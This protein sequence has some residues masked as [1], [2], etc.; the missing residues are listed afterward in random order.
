MKTKKGLSTIVGTVIIIALVIVVGG[1][2]FGV[3]RGIVNDKLTKSK[4]CFNI[5]NKIT[6][7]QDYTCYNSTGNYFQFSI[8]RKKISLDSLKIA[9]SFG[10][11]SKIFTLTNVSQIVPRLNNYPNNN[12]EV[13]LPNNS[14]RSTY[15]ANGIT[16]MPTLIEISPKRMG[17]NCDVADK[18]SSILEC[19]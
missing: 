15:I 8:D 13:M 14:S 17:N 5:Y 11:G 18:I 1:I 12:T 10:S 9:I 7:N 4:A 19:T 6:L 2:V 16:E 3:V